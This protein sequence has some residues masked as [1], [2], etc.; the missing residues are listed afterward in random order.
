MSC[1]LTT[2]ILAQACPMYLGATR[3]GQTGH[4]GWLARAREKVVSALKVFSQPEKGGPSRRATRGGSS[5]LFLAGLWWFS[6]ARG[7]WRTTHLVLP[8]FCFL[9]RR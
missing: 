4:V 7:G 8:C 9:P 6:F 5:A 1:Q 3:I 2:D